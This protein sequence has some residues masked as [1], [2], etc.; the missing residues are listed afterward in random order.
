M[1]KTA[2]SLPQIP[3]VHAIVVAAPI[4]AHASEGSNGSAK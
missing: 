1:R 4:P 2:L 3:T